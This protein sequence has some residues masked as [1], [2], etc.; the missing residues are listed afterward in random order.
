[1][2]FFR[3]LGRQF[4]PVSPAS[5][6]TG[7]SCRQSLKI[8]EESAKAKIPGL[9]FTY[10]EIAKNNFS[11]IKKVKK[12]LDKHQIKLNFVHLTCDESELK[13]RVLNVSRKKF[14]KTKTIKELNYLLSVK[15]YQSVF[16]NSNTL[17]IDNTKIT[18][19]KMAKQIKEHY[20]I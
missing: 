4:I 11:F 14:K 2:Y 17:N 8:F 16:P 12:I 6:I 1:M 13:K 3:R 9:I 19:K 5:D 10:A 7:S 15:D 18:A 20:K